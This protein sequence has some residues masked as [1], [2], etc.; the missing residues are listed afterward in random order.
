[1]VHHLIHTGS[2]SRSD[3]IIFCL[4]DVVNVLRTVVV[5]AAP[6]ASSLLS[7][8]PHRATA[9][10][11]AA[12]V[13]VGSV[14]HEMIHVIQSELLKAFR[15]G[16]TGSPAQQRILA[17]TKSLSRGCVLQPRIARPTPFVS[18]TVFCVHI[19]VTCIRCLAQCFVCAGVVVLAH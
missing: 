2:G 18:V 15:V 13:G 8:V 9:R 4:K 12:L 17:T 10:W 11:I 5:I 6:N 19:C 16:S 1:M 7:P 3:L 14:H